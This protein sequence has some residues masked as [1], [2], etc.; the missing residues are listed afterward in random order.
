M[1]C[2]CS[3]TQPPPALVGGAKK[4]PKKAPKKPTKPIKKVKPTKKK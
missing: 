3:A 1:S 4:V 2:G